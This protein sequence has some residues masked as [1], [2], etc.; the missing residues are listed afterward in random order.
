MLQD[1]DADIDLLLSRRQTAK[2]KSWYPDF[3]PK[4]EFENFKSNPKAKGPNFMLR[5]E[6]ECSIH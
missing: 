1:V 3:K 4:C 6:V 2:E 5:S